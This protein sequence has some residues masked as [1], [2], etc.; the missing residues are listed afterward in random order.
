MIFKPK[1]D[2]AK[3]SER[4]KF[5]NFNNPKIDEEHMKGIL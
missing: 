5:F 4:N 2:I 3:L 1:S